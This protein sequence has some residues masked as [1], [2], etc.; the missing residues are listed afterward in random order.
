VTEL[1]TGTVTFLFTDLEG[2]T[3]LWEE[4]SDEMRRALARHDEI[5]REGVASN[6]GHIVKTTGDGM[7]AVF[8]VPAA[9]VVA[10]I[11]V[12]RALAAERW[13]ET[14]PLRVRM[15]IH[16]GVAD[17]RDGDYFG[18]AVNRAARL[19]SL[20]HGGQVLVSRVCEELLRDSMSTDVTLLDLGVQRL[21]DLSRPESVF[22]VVAPGLEREFPRLQSLDAYATNLASGLSLFVG[23]D[24]E[25]AALVALMP[26]DRLV[27]LTG[28]GGV[29]KTRL[30]TQVAAELLPLFRDGV[31]LCEL[32]AA[33]DPETLAEV[34]AA[35]VGARPQ[36]N[37]PILTTIVDFLRS[38]SVLIVLDNCEHLLTAIGDVALAV[39]RACPDVRILATSREGLGVD[40]ER[41]VAVR[42]LEL[43]TGDDLDAVGD[44]DAA[45]LFAVRAASARPGFVLDAGNA[46]AVAEICSRLDGIPLAIELAAARMGSMTSAE[47]ASHLD[48]RF[49]LLAG[50]R[51]TGIER[52]QTLRS[53]ID[54]SYELLEPRER[55]V[56]DRLGVFVGTFDADAATSVVADD[57]LTPW[58]V[59]DGL[60]D[61]IAKSM[62]IVEEARDRVTQYQMLETLRQYAREQLDT[63]DATDDFRRR[64]AAHYAAWAERAGLELLGPDELRWRTA[65]RAGLDNLRAAVAWSLDASDVADVELAL[66]IVAALSLQAVMDRSAGLSAWAERALAAADDTR[67]EL[68]AG[69]LGAAAW[70]ATRRTDYERACSLADEAMG[71]VA[72][73]DPLHWLSTTSAARNAKSVA[74]LYSG[75]LDEAERLAREGNIASADLQ[76]PAFMFGS[77]V[78]V[79]VGVALMRG[80][81]ERARSEAERALASAR[82]SG[83]PSTLAAALYTLGWVAMYDDEVAALAAFDESLAL[84]REGTIDAILPHVLVRSACIRAGAGDES[85]LRDLRE[86]IAFSRDVGSVVTGMTVLDYGMR[87]AALLGRWEVG[88]GIAGFL[89]SRGAEHRLPTAGPEGQARHEA[90]AR[91]EQG[92]GSARLAPA[93]ASGAQKSY[94]ELIDWLLHQLDAPDAGPSS[95]ETR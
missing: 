37:V 69:V 27:T 56:F 86:A 24:T 8:D 81:T 64:H 47:V 79:P 12:Q 63:T 15:G 11:K 18:S 7:H 19:M 20:A 49:R 70:D 67:P 58:D 34:V 38:R 3:R 28:V 13:D 91:L 54:W 30:A 45:R 53:T 78:I 44:S 17:Q 93:Y 41:M 46:A 77:L 5:L 65:L 60:R 82:A 40:G 74:C 87:I 50:A 21:R 85:A 52:H 80:E 71:L 25:V 59:I 43:P 83:S 9:A 35:S 92:L 62:L 48:E 68:R 1:P 23:R 33:G 36:Q 26:D 88:A 73:D 6:G 10:A 32:A 84:V 4:H 76:L 57:T 51:R 31:W 14:G 90:R 22:Q 95:T 39:L 94:E 29:G 72:T 55:T 75:R 2:S 89:E 42:S 61:L 16:T 66:R